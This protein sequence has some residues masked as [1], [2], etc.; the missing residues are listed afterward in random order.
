[1]SLA[2][3]RAEIKAALD[4]TAGGVVHG[5]T[6]QPT[7]ANEGDG[8]P[9]LGRTERD[10]ATGVF[11]T[12]WSVGVMLPQNRASADAWIDAHA[13]DVVE[14]LW[15]SDALYVDSFEPANFGTDNN[16]VYGLLFTTRS[17]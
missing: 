9:V 5:F 8:W 14:A 2:T 12:T 1:M 13:L 4:A 15:T 16:N 11:V 6:S 10:E 7:S 17:E 3:K